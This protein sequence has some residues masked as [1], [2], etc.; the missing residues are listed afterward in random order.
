MM[1]LVAL[2]IALL[3]TAGVLWTPAV[4]AQ[5]AKPAEPAKPAAKE[6]AKETKA[7][8][9]INSASADD[10]KTLPGI[11]DAY[12]KKIID[13]RPYKGKDELVQKKILPKATYD[14]IKGQIIAKQK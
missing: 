13:G 9:D 10:L 7:P 3:F 6:A 2:L 11:G 12:A 5:A 14:K 1:R 8:L 4:E